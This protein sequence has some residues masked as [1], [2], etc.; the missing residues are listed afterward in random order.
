MGQHLFIHMVCIGSL[1]VQAMPHVP[2]SRSLHV[3]ATLNDPVDIFRWFVPLREDHLGVC[4]GAR[5]LM[6]LVTSIGIKA[7]DAE[8]QSASSFTCQ[9][10]Q[11]SL[12]AATVQQAQLKACMQTRMQV[13]GRALQ[14]ISSIRLRYLSPI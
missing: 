5:G 1:L 2:P 8:Q 14:P 9:R 10:F 3:P 7:Y 6:M 4:K 12:S 11:C 13:A